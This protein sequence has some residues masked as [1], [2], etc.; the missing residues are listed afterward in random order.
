MDPIHGE[1]SSELFQAQAHI[2][3]HIF[4]F[5][6]SMCL[7]SALQ[8]GIPDII[9]N[10]KQP[11]TLPQLVTALQLPPTK[12]SHVHRLMRLLVHSN[13][14]ATT[15]IHVNQEEE[16]EEEGYVLTPCSKL[17]L[18]DE[19]ITLA[20]FVHAAVH[21][22]LFTP[23][24]FLGDWFRSNDI[25]AFQTA[26]GVKMWEFGD[27]NPEFNNIFNKAMASESQMMRLIVG[28]CKDI[29]GELHSLVDV[30]GGTGVVARIVLEAFPHIKCTVFDLP[31]VVASSPEC[32][33]LNYVG[34]NMFQSIPSADAILLKCVL[35]NWSDEDC[36][37]IL[38]RCREAIPSKGGG[39]VIII[40]MVIN[41]DQKDEHDIAETKLVY[42]ILMMVQVTGK[43]RNEKE[44]KK[45]FL[46]AG[47]SSYK[48]APIFGLRSVIEVFP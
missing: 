1:E 43:E 35:H 18:K 5:A 38:K 41:G 14:F 34:G 11:I 24:Q 36:V 27:Q 40:D 42:D 4:N 32:E 15:K 47:F 26:H 8:L 37:K 16:E 7:S 29:F 6:N 13:F 39:K 23:W 12:T 22:V 2:Y 44:W 25:N 19:L 28:D 10:H 45:L 17:L 31:Q 21:P 9:H 20:P 46:E 30:G 33:N 48:I 3:K